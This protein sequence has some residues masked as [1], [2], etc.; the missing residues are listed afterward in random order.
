MSEGSILKILIVE[1]DPIDVS[2]IVH[3]LS[4]LDMAFIYKAVS[5]KDEIV[6]SVSDEEWNLVLCDFRLNDF[7]AFWVMKVILELK[8]DLPMIVVSGAVGEETAVDL[9]RSGAR[10]FLNKAD[11]QRLPMII[12]REWLEFK[13]REEKY[14]ND[15]LLN[16][17]SEVLPNIIWC[18]DE[19][20]QM[21]YCNGM[22]AF[23]FGDKENMN[24]RDWMDF[25]HE[26]DHKAFHDLLVEEERGIQSFECRLRLRSGHH[27]W[28]LV[29]ILSLKNENAQ[30]SGWLCSC[31]NISDQKKAVQVRDDFLVVA[32]HEL[33]TPLTSLRL[34]LEFLKRQ[35]SRV[36]G[37]EDLFSLDMSLK[38]VDRINDITEDFV[39]AA[40]DKTEAYEFTEVSLN[41]L[42]E[43]WKK[44]WQEEIDRANCRL[45]LIGREKIV[46]K[47]DRGKLLKTLG[48]LTSNALKYAP[49]SVIR[50]ELQKQGEQAVLSIK[51]FGKGIAEEDQQRVFEKYERAVNYTYASGLGMG[52]YHVRKIV[53]DHGGEVELKSEINKGTE[54]KITLPLGPKASQA[55]SVH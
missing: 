3:E 30:F 45:E 31:T 40:R 46:G 4:F 26:D 55:Y 11:M 17:I 22:W 52:L 32:S 41:E 7:D 1:D 9:M 44:I 28:H 27:S 29:S 47:W 20:G 10:D 48:H 24:L 14:K 33:K 42:L 34:Q 37:S 38:Q 5:T 21:R 36:K 6:V 18:C 13:L 12:K 19:N 25:I 50:V 43:D 16:E 51:D 54:V 53:S 15:S 23:H 49:D 39:D 2:L 8:R 35:L